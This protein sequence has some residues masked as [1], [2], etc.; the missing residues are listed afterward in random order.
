MNSCLL[1]M[2]AWVVAASL[3]WAACVSGAPAP[4]PATT[5]PLALSL[6]RLVQSAAGEQWQ[7]TTQHVVWDASGTAVVVCDMWDHHWCQGA[8][9]RVAEMAPP[10]NRLLESLRQR[11]ILIIHCPSDTMDFYKD[12]PGRKLAQR[13]PKVDIQAQMLACASR[14][15]QTE[16]PHPIDSSDG[17]CDCQP[18][19]KGLEHAPYPWTRQIATLEIKNGDAITDGLEAYYLMHQRDLTNLLVLGVHENMCILN[20][21]FAIKQMVKLGLNVALVRDLTDTMYNSR[22]P[23]Y[24]NHFIGNELMTGHIEKYWCPTLTSD[25]VLGGRPFRFVANIKAPPAE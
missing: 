4:Q 25:Q 15:P 20:R 22:R 10:M 3:I 21:R 12:H 17:S 9:A 8:S 16:P 5:G 24:V 1:K 14:V 6:R 7:A 18:P 2:R 23:P 19:C 11:G 13:A